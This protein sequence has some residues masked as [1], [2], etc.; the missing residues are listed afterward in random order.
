MSFLNVCMSVYI[1]STQYSAR[2][3]CVWSSAGK[4]HSKASGE[5]K[6]HSQ[7]EVLRC[8][9]SIMSFRWLIQVSSFKIVIKYLLSYC[10]T[11]VLSYED[12]NNISL[13]FPS[14]GL[15]IMAL[16][17]ETVP[18]HNL[19]WEEGVRTQLVTGWTESIV[20]MKLQYNGHFNCL[21]GVRPTLPS[22][23][24]NKDTLAPLETLIADCTH[25][26]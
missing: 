12:K 25:G 26:M 19:L 10:L 11:V 6:Q 21:G 7:D 3:S 16:L 23:Y 4:R 20:N 13:C 22:T 9:C 17:T 1:F 8:G 14:F 15:L 24:P 2:S 5:P 18:F